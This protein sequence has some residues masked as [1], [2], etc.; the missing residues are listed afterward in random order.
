MLAFLVTAAIVLLGA[1]AVDASRRYRS[2]RVRPTPDGFAVVDA[3]VV[4]VLLSITAAVLV[5]AIVNI[6]SV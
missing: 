4:G 1:G 2:G 3:L 5:L 6:R